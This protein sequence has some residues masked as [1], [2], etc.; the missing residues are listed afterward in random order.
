MLA[1]FEPIILNF[2]TNDD[3]TIYPLAD[4][5]I[6]AK[7]MLM[8]E[9]V[10]FKNQLLSEPNSY[11]TIGGDMMNNGTKNSVSN[12]YE[13]TMRPREQKRWLADELREIKDKILCVVPGNHEFRSAKEV[14]DNP[15]YDVC[16]KLDIEDRFRENGAVL[17]MRM[18]DMKGDGKRNPSYAGCVLHG[19]GGGFLTGSAIN[20]NERFG[21]YFDGLDF[22]IVGH[23]HKPVNTAPSKIYIDKQ[24]R[25]VSLK[26]FRVIVST[27]WL[28]Y[29]GY[30]FRGQMAPA[31]H[32]LTEIKLCGHKKEMRVTQ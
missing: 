24:N 31:T 27:A 3:I 26:P 23:T 12:V 30:A 9:W 17:L 1:D 32:L 18:G 8:K 29:S 2:P 16:C 20:K 5:H 6:G 10:R 14:D 25:K 7:E 22:L 28:D 13:E 19:S 11:V 4:L 21:Y 15:L